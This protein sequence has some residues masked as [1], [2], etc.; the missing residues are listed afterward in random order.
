MWLVGTLLLVPVLYILSVGPAFW[1]FSTT[2]DADW[3]IRVAHY[4]QPAIWLCDLCPWFQDSLE[5]YMSWWAA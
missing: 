4:L 3:A 2:T 5:W 1:F